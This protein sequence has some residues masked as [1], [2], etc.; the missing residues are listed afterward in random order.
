MVP[1]NHKEVHANWAVVNDQSRMIPNLS[2]V[3]QSILEGLPFQGIHSEVTCQ[4]ALSSKLNEIENKYY[5]I[6]E[7]FEMICLL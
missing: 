3:V 2:Q 5:E 4:G 1:V 6:I 7:K